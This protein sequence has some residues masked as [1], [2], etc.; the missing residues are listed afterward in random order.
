MKFFRFLSSN[1]LA[2]GVVIGLLLL[3]LPQ[4]S[5]AAFLGPLVSA[6]SGI[7]YLLFIYIPGWALAYVTRV[8][9][10]VLSYQGYGQEAIITKGWTVLRDLSNMFFI[11]VLVVVAVGTIVKSGRY[12]YQQNLRRLILMAILINFSKTI[13]LFFIDLS[14]AI[15][16]SFVNAFLDAIQ[17]G[18]PALLG[19]T[20]ILQI[21]SGAGPD[22]SNSGNLAVLLQIGLGGIML[23]VALVVVCVITFLFLMRIIYFAFIIILSPVAFLCSTLPTAQKYYFEWW[24]ILGKYLVLGPTL[25]FFLWLSFAVVKEGGSGLISNRISDKST[26]TVNYS[27]TESPITAPIGDT[28]SNTY[29]PNQTSD[30]MAKSLIRFFVAISLL[31]GS[32]MMAGRLGTVGAGISK[33][34]SGT[35]TGIGKSV[36]VGRSGAGGLAGTARS[37]AN[38]P[39][40][41][42]ANALDRGNQLTNAGVSRV[43]GFVQS[44]VSKVAGQGAGRFA[45]DM[46]RAVG[47]GAAQVAFGAAV[48]PYHRAARE[49]ARNDAAS[50]AKDVKAKQEAMKNDPERT[51]L[52]A[53]N[54]VDRNAAQAAAVL[55]QKEGAF[56]NPEN[57]EFRKAA[58]D[59]FAAGGEATA[60]QYKE[61][62]STHTDILS[63]EDRINQWKA[64]DQAG[65]SEKYLAK[66]AYWTAEM[67]DD[68]RAAGIKN[69]DIEA[70]RG[71]MTRSTGAG[72]DTAYQQ[73]YEKMFKAKQDAAGGGYYNIATDADLIE[74]AQLGANTNKKNAH[75]YA[76]D[77]NRSGGT[78]S[79]NPAHITVDLAYKIGRKIK[80]KNASGM[81]PEAIR[82]YAPFAPSG[83]LANIA[84]E[85]GADERDA[86][87]DSV[88][89]FHSRKAFYGI[90][91]GS[92]E[93]IAIDRN[94]KYIDT[95]EHYS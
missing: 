94:K 13:T 9:V 39:I 49:F 6:I 19:L 40:S 2:L 15:T 89:D 44:N 93:D 58:L 47:K 74:A 16:I 80:P 68:L 35:L 26:T 63:K 86:V 95:N 91:P 10:W 82:V 92:P 18:F 29:D 61:F 78:L 4:V 81:S 64:I 32:L 65:E 62:A 34:A 73:N 42:L 24:D 1:R 59:A 30:P 72:F 67:L 11:I 28:T 52:N 31:F 37:L 33:K 50:K 55:L 60:E 77:L 8:L 22:L 70:A 3:V 41:G 85:A 75:L 56:L 36:L 51:K 90:A 27:N 43:S 7:Y 46:T 71:K 87:L 88:R 20:G 17:G 76:S 25:A 38:I 48:N 12:G 23:L 84:Q 54:D 79:N 14:Q 66:Q 69:K 83:A 53:L 57:K 5:L 45:G 21:Q